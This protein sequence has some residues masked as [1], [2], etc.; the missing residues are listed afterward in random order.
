VAL[1]AFMEVLDTSIANVAL[2]HIAGD[3]GASTDQG[4][5][6]LT[7]YLVSN[8]IVLPAGAWA[9]SVIG[10][11]NFFCPASRCSRWRVFSAALRRRC[12]SCWSR[13]S[14]REPAAAG[15]SPWRR[16]SWRTRLREAARAGVCA[17]RSGGRA[18]AL[19]RSHHGRLDHGQLLVALDLLH[20]HSR[21]ILAFVLVSRLVD[22]P[23]WIKA[24]GQPEEP[25]LHWAGLSALAMAGMQIFLDKGEEDA[26]FAS[27]FIRVFRDAVHRGMIGLIAWEWRK[28]KSAD[29]PEA[30]QV[31]EL[32]HLRSADDPGGR[33]VERATVL[34][35]QFM[36]ALLGYTATKAGEALTGGGIALLIVMPLAGIA[37]GRFAARNLAC[38][39]LHLLCTFSFYFTS[40]HTTLGHVLRL[41]HLSAH[42]ADGS[43][44]VLLYRD[45]QRSVCGA[46]ARGVQPGFGHY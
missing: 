23:P 9:S 38:D 34:Q 35:P 41:Q 8:A 5:W 11:K 33:R 44:P 14:S 45:H 39:W 26:W 19:H 7:S 36:Q 37:T 16:R 1:A 28:A 32:C 17:V 42:P 27:N 46:A 22:D 31:Q 18:G 40:T 21:R 3:L 12:R 10:R 13:A 4:T 29:E 2:P 15:C 30:L 25:G 20:Q 43:D 24:T 6:V